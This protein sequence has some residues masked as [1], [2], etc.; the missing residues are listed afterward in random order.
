MDDLI[1]GSDGQ[2]RGASVRVHSSG[3]QCTV[4]RR[5]V[6]L[7]YLLEVRDC[8]DHNGSDFSAPDDSS[9][10]GVEQPR[11]ESSTSNNQER[12]PSRA[13]QPIQGE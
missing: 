3:R 2:V 4:L 6:Q 1:T 11:G 9:S 13:P 10:A 12:G 8:V 7:L 5:P